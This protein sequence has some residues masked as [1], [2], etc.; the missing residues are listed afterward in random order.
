[1]DQVLYAVG[2]DAPAATLVGIG[3]SVAWDT[4]P[5]ADIVR[6]LGKRAQTALNVA[7]ALAGLQL[8]K[9]HAKKLIIADKGAH[10]VVAL[11]SVH[12]FTECLP[13][14]KLHQLR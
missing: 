14:D 1:M 13:W 3:Q 4:A 5:K 10:A 2:V 9:G 8:G 6:F 11:I 12:T 7:Q